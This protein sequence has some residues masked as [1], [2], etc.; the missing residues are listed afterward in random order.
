MSTERGDCDRGGEDAPRAGPS[1]ASVATAT[2][3]LAARLKAFAVPDVRRS[4]AQ[5]SVTVLGFGALWGAAWLALDV[6]YWLTLLLSVPTAGFL[7]RLFVL[8]HDCGHGSFFR[9]RRANDVV[10]RALGVLTL[11][12]Y[13]HWRAAHA[14]H[15]ATSGNLDRRGVGDITI[16][17]VRE[18]RALSPWRR[19]AYRLYRHPI[20]LFALIPTF[21]FV[22]LRRLPIGGALR[23]PA[24]L[25][26]VLGN[27][28][29][30]AAL[31]GA[32]VV[33]VGPIDFLLVQLPITA[34]AST[35]GVWLFFVQHQFKHQAWFQED[36]WSF[37]AAALGGSSHLRLPKALQWLTANIG[38]HH[39]HHLASRIPNYR[40]QECLDRTPELNGGSN[41]LSLADSMACAR[42][43]LWSEE[44]RRMIRFR[45]LKS[46]TAVGPVGDGRSYSV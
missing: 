34:V 8:Q 15:H 3:G 30:L 13:A 20:V 25:V 36:E 23:W 46:E 43:T 41:Q 27:N 45:D 31:I 5:L 1:P 28:L 9:S 7:I 4:I 16:L 21:L 32:M 19:L 29:A 22:V 14:A 37:E 18:Y 44:S 42:L 2:P 6:G 35:I 33:A 11:T 17:T 10:G 40:L 38:L 24:A 39:V 12:P 26:S